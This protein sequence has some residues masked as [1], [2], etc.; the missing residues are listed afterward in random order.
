MIENFYIKYIENRKALVRVICR[1]GQWSG[2]EEN[3]IFN[4]LDNF[5]DSFGKYIALKILIHSIYYSEKNVIALLKH[6]IYEKILS[7]DIKEQLILNDNILTPKTETN[8]LLRERVKRTTFVPLL[9]KGKPGESAN[10]ITR[11]LIQKIYI[12]PSQTAFIDN[13]NIEDIVQMTSLIFVDDCIGSGNQ[14]DLFFNRDNVKSK[15]DIAVQN[16]VKVYYLILT[17]Y[18]K[19]ID[20]VQKQRNLEKIKIVACDELSDNDRIFNRNNVIWQDEEEYEKANQYFIKLEKEYGIL[21]FGWSDLDFSVFIHNTIPDWSLPI[22]WMENSDWT[23][24]M[25][26]KNSNLY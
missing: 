14:L 17:G 24:L 20:T 21:Q 26:R 10:Q 13:L 11:Y 9:D 2:L 15:I 3:E 6:G 19:N 12:D 5:K 23:P 7:K 16:K 18:K 8:A 4:W 22:F 1:A 25:K